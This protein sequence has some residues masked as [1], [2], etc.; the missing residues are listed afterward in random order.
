II[1]SQ[2]VI[3]GA[4][5]LTQ[6]AIQLGLL[7]RLEIR[8]TSETQAGQIYMPQVNWI[9]LAGVLILM[10]AFETSTRLAAAY[11]ISITGERIMSSCM[12]FIV[13]WKMW[14]QPLPLAVLIMLPFAL[15]ELI[16]LS[17][18]LRR[19]VE[20]GFVPLALAG[21]LILTM[22]TWTRGT[23][24]LSENTRRDEPLAKL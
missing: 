11:G 5:S 15:I 14:K 24:I 1:A 21:F 3:S 22:W 6:Q 9:L 20:G 8:R 18:N 2:A 4:Y 12:A 13:I 7:P 19:V 16:F 10:F 17:S 23:R